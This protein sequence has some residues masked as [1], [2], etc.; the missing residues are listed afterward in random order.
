M[1]RGWATSKLGSEVSL[2]RRPQSRVDIAKSVSGNLA[3]KENPESCFCGKKVLLEEGFMSLQRVPTTWRGSQAGPRSQ[4]KV[5]WLN[6]VAI[7]LFPIRSNSPCSG[8]K[9]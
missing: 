5:A 9:P 2:G 8:S 7:K 4:P 3:L 1:G 6:I